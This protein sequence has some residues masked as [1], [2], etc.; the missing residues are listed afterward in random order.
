MPAKES[1]GEPYTA[2]LD[3]AA[4]ALMTD[5][6]MEAMNAWCNRGHPSAEHE[7]GQETRKM[8]S[9]FRRYIAEE[10]G[11]DLVG[12]DA[13]DIIFTSG[14]SESNAQI[15]TSAVRSYA[16]KTRRLPHVI[17][18]ATEH[19][20]VAQCCARLQKEQMCQLTVL[21][22][23]RV[24]ADL[25]QVSLAALNAAIRPNT[26]LVTILAA[27][28]D[29]GALNN[30]RRLSQAARRAHV[31]FHT[32][33]AQL[34]GKSAFRPPE[35]GVDAFSASF[36]K[37]GG[38]PGVGLLVV[39]RAVIEGYDLGAHVAGDQN[40]GMR[41]GTENAPGLGASFAALRESLEGRADK[42]DRLLRMRSAVRLALA[43]HFPCFPVSEHAPR[44]SESIDGGITPPPPPLSVESEG[45]ARA[46]R[47]AEKGGPA[48]LFWVAPDDDHRSLPGILLVAVRRPGF[49]AAAARA[50]L[51]R[52]GV[53]V[54]GGARPSVAQAALGLHPALTA[55][56]LRV[57]M[58]D[59]T[60]GKDVK[61][62]VVALIE[63]LGSDECL[64]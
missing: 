46:L 29:T 21:P 38:P 52:R 6:A 51:E 11:V 40:N 35:L 41:G 9:A 56:L 43:A 58:G 20:S 22:V 17:T 19:P 23:G 26:C 25:G 55:G 13:Y 16:A 37:I 50:A 5:K 3:N 60:T 7:G 39:R 2:Y 31:P 59:R 27:S 32:D 28:G 54:G 62:L 8:M 4:T 61:R 53:V 47:E 44:A 1:D 48:A 14:A 34:F 63:V 12:R 36:H 33:A 24:G 42:N 57:S 45:A 64:A 49:S 15:I 30:L 18:S 10:C